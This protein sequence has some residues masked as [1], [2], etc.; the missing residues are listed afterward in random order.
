MVDARDSSTT[1]VFA[2]S[3]V[4]FLPKTI[5]NNI[6]MNKAL[7]RYLLLCKLIKEQSTKSCISKLLIYN[8]IRII[9][10]YLALFN[11]ASEFVVVIKFQ[12]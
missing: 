2:G 8:N 12:I 1:N 7:I 10:L 4:L 11:M 3:L 9:H 6:I 5:Y